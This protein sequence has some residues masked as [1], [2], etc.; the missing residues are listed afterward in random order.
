VLYQASYGEFTMN[1]AILREQSIEKVKSRSYP[2]NEAIATQK[3]R[4]LIV[5]DSVTEIVRLTSILSKMGDKVISAKDGRQA[6]EILDNDPIALI[7]SD[8]RMP[9]LTGIDLC[10]LLRADPKY[11]QPYFILLTGFHTPIDLIAGMDAGADDFISKPFISEE[12][13][14]RLQAGMRIIQ[15]RKKLEQQNKQLEQTLRNEEQAN[16]RIQQDLKAAAIMQRDLLPNDESPFLQL[17][18]ASL[19]SP[20]VVVAGDSYNY[21]SLDDEHLGFYHLDVAGHGIASA[22]LSFTLSRVLSPDAPGKNFL[23][24]KLQ[25]AL[26]AIY[27]TQVTPPHEVIDSL[28]QHFL[29]KDNCGHYFTMVYGVLN[30]ITGLGEFCQ[31][32]H[33]HPLICRTDGTMETMG[34]GGFP[35]GMLAEAVYES[36]SFQLGKGDR[37]WLYS[38][39]IP[40]CNNIKGQ[41]LGITQL[42]NIISRAAKASASHIPDF[43]DSIIKRWNGDRPLEDDISLLVIGRRAK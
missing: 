34:N 7:I 36:T 42:S 4:L 19:F 17:E 15:L 13:R 2:A 26:K 35:V 27:K 22:M 10:R 24:N 18:L 25:I 6:L 12:L 30:V 11:G 23:T 16:Q 31:A 3:E 40:D 9:E 21:F 5:E 38:D 33:P 41:P 1:H 43:V 20:A 28:N 29:D 14:V 8:W 39:G 37:L 32:G